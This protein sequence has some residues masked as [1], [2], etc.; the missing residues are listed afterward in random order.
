MYFS[1]NTYIVSGSTMFLFLSVFLSLSKV[2]LCYPLFKYVF[3][4][5]KK[6]TFTLYSLS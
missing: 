1:W 4:W 3:K 2:R 6:L 5:F